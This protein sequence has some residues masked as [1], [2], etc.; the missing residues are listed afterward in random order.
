VEAIGEIVPLIRRLLDAGAAYHVEEDVYFSVDTAPR[1]GYEAGLDVPTMLALSAERGGDPE[2]PGKK[3][4]LDP[5]LWRA[6]RAGEPSWDSELGPGRPGWHVECAAIALNRLG[7]GFDV[8]G[9][10]SDLAFPHHEMSAAHAE[11]ALGQWPFARHYVHAGMISL[12]GAKMSKSLGNLV[13]VSRLLADG[14]DPAAIRLALLAGHYRSDRAW[15]GELLRT[16]ESRLARWRA[17][18]ALPAGPDAAPVLAAVRHQLADDLDTP[19]ALATIDRWSD[20]ALLHHT[21]D[22]AAPRAVRDLTDAL[23]GLAL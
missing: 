21:R 13:L 23:L 22:P 5:V 11:S 1:F 17:A 7:L 12:D 9:G 20:E 8:Q 18:V 3:N 2:R 6:A 14:V 4:P 19:A 16:A 10:G 15:T